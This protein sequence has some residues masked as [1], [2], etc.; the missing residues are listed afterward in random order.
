MRSSFKVKVHHSVSAYLEK[1]GWYCLDHDPAVRKT[2]RYSYSDLEK[3]T[4]GLHV[5]RSMLLR[6]GMQEYLLRMKQV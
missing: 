5:E 3:H 6:N 4:V 2:P 1:I